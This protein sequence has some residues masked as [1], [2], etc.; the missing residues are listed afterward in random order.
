[1]ALELTD[2]DRAILTGEAGEAAALAMRILVRM[3]EIEGAPRFIPIESVHVDG[4]AYEGDAILEFV[5]RLASLGGRVRVP[6]TLNAVSVEVGNWRR[7]HIP[8]EFGQK[9]TR[10][11]EGYLKMGCSPTFSCSPYQVGHRPAFG[12]NVAWAESNAIAFANSVLGA[13]TD[14]YGDFLDICAALTGRVPEVGLHLQENRR[15]QVVFRLGDDIGEDLRDSDVLYPVL[16]YLVGR[17]TENRI[18]VI[19]GLP[20]DAGE[21][22]LKAFLAASASSGAVALAHFVGLTPE[23]PDL[24]TALQGRPPEETVIVGKRDLRAAYEEL[25]A[26]S[27]PGLDAVVLG[28]PHFSP[29]EFSEFARHAAGLTRDSSVRVLITT[30]RVSLAAAREAGSLAEVER[31]GAEAVSDTCIL[32][33]PLL[34]PEVRTIMTNSGKYA[35]YSP[36][37]LGVGVVFGSLR[38]CV[39]S[40]AAGRVVLEDALWN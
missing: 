5:E 7:L 1:M 20:G 19:E 2:A 35:H 34:G 30:S 16:G 24:E 10:I 11:V 28:S 40:A 25:N 4:C 31:F 29:Q 18:P 12:Q 8:E 22:R 21:D 37:R 36:G 39:R 14:R 13:R 15:G 17:R 26:E 27:G 6:T 23:A 32:L 38:D 9:A 33:A 3:A